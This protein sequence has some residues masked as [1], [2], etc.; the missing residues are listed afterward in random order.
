M[1][2]LKAVLYEDREKLSFAAFLQV[3][4]RLRG[5][6]TATV[7]DVTELRNYMRQRFETFEAKQVSECRSSKSDDAPPPWALTML[8][9]LE[10]LQKGQASLFKDVHEIRQRLH[11][12]DMRESEISS[13]SC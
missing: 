1:G 7:T 3:V 5:G 11:L 9:R 4:L 8:A 6:N 10:E 2:A 13:V 12:D